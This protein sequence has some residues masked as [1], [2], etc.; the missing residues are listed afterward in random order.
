MTEAWRPWRRSP[1]SG[2]TRSGAPVDHAG[3]VRLFVAAWPPRDAVERLRPF[4]CDLRHRAAEGAAHLAW[5]ASER[6]HVTLAFLGDADP[7]LAIAALAGA[8]GSP[9]WPV[10]APVASVGPSTAVFAPST[11]FLPVA[12]VDVLA[13]AVDAGV[14]RVIPSPATPSGGRA[15]AGEERCASEDELHSSDRLGQHFTGHLT[16][17]RARRR[18]PSAALSSLAGV[19]VPP[20]ISWTVREAVL[21]NSERSAGSSRYVIVGR[22]PI[23]T[24]GG[25]GSAPE[26]LPDVRR[27]VGGSGGPP[28]NICS[29]LESRRGRSRTDPPEAVTTHS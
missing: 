1:G 29:G 13:A 20:E 14:R 19:P 5:T 2:R 16:V 18:A 6:W 24:S 12:G 8:A 11:L 9:Q 23:G 4:V 22:V 3:A 26:G 17:A 28:S 27:A 15:A 10:E 21:V 25:A 7:D